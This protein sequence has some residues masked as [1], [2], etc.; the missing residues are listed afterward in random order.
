MATAWPLP[1]TQS[2]AHAEQYLPKLTMPMNRADPFFER[3][4]RD[5]NS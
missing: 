4:A 3:D 5:G 2:Y 1:Y